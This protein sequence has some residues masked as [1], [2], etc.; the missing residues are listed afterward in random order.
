SV[1]HGIQS[2]HAHGRQHSLAVLARRKGK[3]MTEEGTLSIVRRENNY[4]VRYAS[5]NPRSL[6]R[7]PYQCTDTEALGAFLHQ[8]TLDASY[9]KQVFVEL[10]KGGFPALP[11]VLSAEQIQAYFLYPSTQG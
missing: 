1:I 10:W 8:L 2:A 7:Q 3:T 11:I 9:I 6:D 4:N 5:N